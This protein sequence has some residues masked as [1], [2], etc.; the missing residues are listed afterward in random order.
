MAFPAESVLFTCHQTC[1]L[2]K[3]SP[4]ATTFETIFL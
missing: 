2:N 1:Q 4:I 3:I